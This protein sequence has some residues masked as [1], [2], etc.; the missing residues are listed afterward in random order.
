MSVAVFLDRIEAL[1]AEWHQW[2]Q[3]A[4]AGSILSNE[5]RDIV[6]TDLRA[7][8]CQDAFCHGSAFGVLPRR[9]EQHN[10]RMFE[11]HRND[12]REH[13]G[14][15]DGQMTE[16]KSCASEVSAAQLTW[17]VLIDMTVFLAFLFFYLYCYTAKYYHTLATSIGVVLLI[18]FLLYAAPRAYKPALSFRPLASLSCSSEPECCEVRQNDFFFFYDCLKRTE[19]QL[20]ALSALQAEFRSFEEQQR[21]LFLTS[22]SQND[23]LNKNTRVFQKLLKQMSCVEHHQH[24]CQLLLLALASMFELLDSCCS[25]LP[26][27]NQENQENGVTAVA[28]SEAFLG[29]SAVRTASHT[30]TITT[31]TPT[32]ALTDL[33]SDDAEHR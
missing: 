8:V 32:E 15:I 27:L 24:I 17:S 9:H 33:V 1:S 18:C 25:H 29:V 16:Q 28:G 23:T 13:V 30:T 11:A 22:A 12:E 21:K 14:V 20:A 2:L 31:M 19:T 7:S 6:R 4:S 3:R 10:V 26:N 5:Q